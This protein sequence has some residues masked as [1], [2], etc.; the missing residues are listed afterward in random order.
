MEVKFTEHYKTSKSKLLEI[1]ALKQCQ[2]DY[3]VNENLVWMN[4]NILPNDLHVIMTIGAENVA[5]MNLVKV[6]VTINNNPKSFFGIGNVCAKEK[7]KGFGKILLLEVNKYLK[8]NNVS[9]I[10]FCKDDLVD[11]YKKCNWNVVERNYIKNVNL[12]SVNVM[13]FNE[14]EIVTNIDYNDR[15]F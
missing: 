11:F 15:I 10:L 14:R 12:S 3:T 8:S 5:Y 4:T 2:W 1:V 9:G 13:V 6:Q 7:G